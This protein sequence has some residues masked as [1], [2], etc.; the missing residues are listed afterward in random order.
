LNDIWINANAFMA[1]E[2]FSRKFKEHSA[3][4]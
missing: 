1:T 2:N 3:I 4:S